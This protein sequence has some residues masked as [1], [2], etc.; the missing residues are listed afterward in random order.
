FEKCCDYVTISS[1]ETPAIKLTSTNGIATVTGSIVNVTFVSDGSV[2]GSGFRLHFENNTNVFVEDENCGGLIIGEN[3]LLN[4]KL[5]TYYPNNERCVYL[6]HSPN[7]RSIT[8]ELLE[9]EFEVCCDFL[10]VNTIDPTNGTL[11]NDTVAITRANNTRTFDESLL[12]IV[13]RSDS[14]TRGKGFSL[15]FTSNGTNANLGYNYK[16]RHVSD[17]YGTI[18]YPSA[19]WGD[20]E[21]TNNE[22]FVLASSLNTRDGDA[23]F[24]S[25]I[26]W[27]SGTFQKSNDSC[28]YGSLSFYSTQYFKGWL[29]RPRLPSVNATS[30]CSNVIHE[31]ARRNIFNTEF[32]SFLAI[33]K[34]IS[35]GVYACLSCLLLHFCLQGNDKCGGVYVGN[36]SG[37]I[38]YK[39]NI[40]Y[41]AN[42]QCVFLVQVP[43]A[44]T[45]VFSL[46]TR[47]FED[48]CD[49]VT[50]GS[51]AAFGET[52]SPPV[53]MSTTNSTTII[54]GSVAIVTFTSDGSIQQ[55]GFRLQFHARTKATTNFQYTYILA[56]QNQPPPFEFSQQMGPNQVA[57]FA[58]AR[59]FKNNT[60]LNI[61]SFRPQI[62]AR[63]DS[64]SLSIY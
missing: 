27:N 33:Y 24:T 5:R 45:I 35:V 9:D 7:S 8:L 51:L 22:I 48:C 13:F 25:M 37:E 50:V 55:F 21:S 54:T 36:N 61:T 19:E 1:A 63:C 20:E 14:G 43:Q 46:Q 60:Q 39:E 32:S 16:L 17:S 4:Y 15:Q 52:Q 12:V 58:Y 11:R 42:E 62:N 38:I 28:D 47:G 56:H 44:E 26:N 64:D 30:T 29:E 41:D 3:G 31:P 18:D 40:R 53:I 10:H 2:M 59:S 34:P 23:L 49:Y 6:L 57:I